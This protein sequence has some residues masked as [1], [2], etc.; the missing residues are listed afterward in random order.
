MLVSCSSGQ[1]VGIDWVPA[2]DVRPAP[3]SHWPEVIASSLHV[4]RQ[5]QLRE[6][7]DRFGLLML[8]LRPIW[9]LYFQ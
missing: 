3:A 4:T 1:Y 5:S 7:P 9:C 2:S 6:R 8:W